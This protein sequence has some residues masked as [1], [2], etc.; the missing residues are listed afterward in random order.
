MKNQR[1]LLIDVLGDPSFDTRALFDRTLE[2]A[3]VTNVDLERNAWLEGDRIA[4]DDLADIYD[5]LII[6]GSRYSVVSDAH[7]EWMQDLSTFIQDVQGCIPVLGVCFGHQLLASS[8]GGSVIKHPSGRAM[9]TVRIVLAN[10][11]GDRLLAGLPNEILVNVSHLDVVTSLP[12]G[13]ELLGENTHGIY[14][15]R[16]GE[17]WGVQFHPEMT[18]E[19]AIALASSRLAPT[20]S[21][22]DR[23]VFERVI[24][25]AHDAPDGDRVLANFVEYLKTQGGSND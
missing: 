7:E 6:S 13:S 11:A 8:L 25:T 4:V 23:E 14:V 12:N 18:G 21:A 9:G 17:S 10:E 1:I 20:N 22:F 24:E 19:I 16:V 5:G 2:R 15:F 3:G